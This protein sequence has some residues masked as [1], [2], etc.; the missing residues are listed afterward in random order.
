[1]AGISL[2]PALERLEAKID[3]LATRQGVAAQQPPLQSTSD[4][5]A[6]LTTLLDFQ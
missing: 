5:A 2:L 4:E 3:A 1:M 6:M